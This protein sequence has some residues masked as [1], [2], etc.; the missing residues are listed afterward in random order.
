[1]LSPEEQIRQESGLISECLQGDRKAQFRLYDRYCKAMLN[2]S[3]RVLK[4]KELAE[5]ALQEAFIE[6]FSRLE[7]FRGESTIG[8]WIRRIVINKSI[9]QLKKDSSN[10]EEL[11]ENLEQR[12]PEND[13]VIPPYSSAE[14]NEAI[15]SLPTGFR[16]VFSL[17][18][19]EGYDHKEIASILEI[20]ESTSKTQYKRAKERVRSILK[21]RN[22]D[23]G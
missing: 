14:I 20:S 6:V 18:L 22:R 7:S 3:F 16:T 12:E 17:Y 21:E 4:N 5:D 10:Q 19:L 2:T 11:P 8:A 23:H 15:L 9:N 13:E 1:M